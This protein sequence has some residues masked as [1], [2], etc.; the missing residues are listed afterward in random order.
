MSTLCDPLKNSP[1]ESS[2]HGI[3]QAKIRSGYFL[4]RGSSDPGIETVSHRAGSFFTAEPSE[5]LSM[6][7]PNVNVVMKIFQAINNLEYI[8]MYLRLPSI[9]SL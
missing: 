1:T 8:Y 6:I 5:K 9:S 2:V 7:Y 3:F 4:L